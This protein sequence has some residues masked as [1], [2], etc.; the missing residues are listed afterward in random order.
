MILGEDER[1]LRFAEKFLIQ[2]GLAHRREIFLQPVPAGRGAGEQHVRKRFP[3]ELKAIRSQ[4]QFQRKFLL[5]LIDGDGRSASQRHQQLELACKTTGVTP[6]GSNDP[7][8]VFIPCRNLETWVMFLLGNA[9]DEQTDYKQ[10][11]SEAD[12]RRA[13]I[14]LADRC[15]E[16]EIGDAAP[17]SLRTAC[18]DFNRLKI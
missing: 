15:R 7:A 6:F 3:N 12:R 2:R 13:A 8:C 10:Q 16:N 11:V 1:H 17:V 5:V 9:V 18:A 4:S 14:S